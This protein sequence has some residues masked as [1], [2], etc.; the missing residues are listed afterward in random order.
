M[1]EPGGAL[2]EVLSECLG[3]WGDWVPGPHV[4]ALT[5]G[6]QHVTLFEDRS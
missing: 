3:V 2:G 1:Q 4:E 5:P 6:P